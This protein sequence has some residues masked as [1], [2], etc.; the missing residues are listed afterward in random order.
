[1]CACGV[2]ATMTS[3]HEGTD[4]KHM[5][6]RAAST[7]CEYEVHIVEVKIQR[8]I[9]SLS[10]TRQG[11]HFLM[12]QNPSPGGRPGEL[13]FDEWRLCSMIDE[14]CGERRLSQR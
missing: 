14:D 10:S 13:Q 12:K 2:A 7:A 8:P 5:E 6:I 3:P 1:M 11:L 4:E 9:R